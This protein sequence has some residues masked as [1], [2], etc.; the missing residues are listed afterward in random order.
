MDSLLR[1]YVADDVRVF[2]TSADNFVSLSL[3]P[4]RCKFFDRLIGKGNLGKR[5][6]IR[7][8]YFKRC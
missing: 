6:S 8:E 4:M 1:N 2:R 7:N 3:Y 5:G